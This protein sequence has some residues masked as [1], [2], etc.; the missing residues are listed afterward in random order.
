MH[1]VHVSHISAGSV[2]HVRFRTIP[3]GIHSYTLI[4][5]IVLLYPVF[6]F[7]VF[8]SISSTRS[9]EALSMLLVHTAWCFT[10]FSLQITCD[11][12]PIKSKMPNSAKSTTSVTDL[13][14]FSPWYNL[15]NSLVA[16]KDD[17]SDNYR[18]NCTESTISWL[19]PTENPARDISPEEIALEKSKT[20]FSKRRR[21]NDDESDGRLGEGRKAA[22][23][24]D[25]ARQSQP[26]LACPFY[27][28]Y[29]TRH[30]GKVCSRGWKSIHRLK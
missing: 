4:I 22:R 28:R 5:F 29:P 9:S 24:T 17:T 19:S 8:T 13:N 30:G 27:K 1:L 6:H 18:E 2:G 10:P 15:P 23:V 12:P 26:R 20:E 21:C 11:S 25:I 14:I 7:F 16:A 3:S